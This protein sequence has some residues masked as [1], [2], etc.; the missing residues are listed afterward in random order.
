M[1]KWFGS[2]NPEVLEAYKAFWRDIEA[3]TMPASETVTVLRRVSS[4]LGAGG[5]APKQS[6][7]SVSAT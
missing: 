7:S 2:A 6:R 4:E 5:W 3:A 1:S